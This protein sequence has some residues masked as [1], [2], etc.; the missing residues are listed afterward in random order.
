MASR[1]GKLDISLSAFALEKL[2]SRDEFG[3]PIPRQPAHLHTQ[4][5]SG[6]YFYLNRHTLSGKFR[7]YVVSNCVPMASTAENSPAQGQ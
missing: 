6:A 2:I 4:A 1:T 7:V 3:S 5:E